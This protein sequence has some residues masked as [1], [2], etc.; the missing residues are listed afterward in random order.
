M[1]KWAGFVQEFPELHEMGQDGKI[2]KLPKGPKTFWGSEDDKDAAER[3]NA[4]NEWI[5]YYLELM[6]K[7]E[8]ISTLGGTIHKKKK[9][10][11]QDHRRNRGPD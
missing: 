1:F 11:H 5:A 8:S 10:H 7:Y 6:R 2:F 9:G 4:L 3:C